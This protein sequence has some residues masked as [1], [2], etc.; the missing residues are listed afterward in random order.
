MVAEAT[1]AEETAA[2]ETQASEMV[3]EGGV[4]SELQIGTTLEIGSE[5][6]VPTVR[7][8]TIIRGKVDKDGTAIATGR[9]KTAVARVRLKKGTGK[10][11]INDRTFEQYFPVER[12][13][14]TIQQP[15]EVTG[16]LGKVDIWCRASGGGVNGQ[17]GAMILGIARAIQAIEPEQHGALSDGGFL[18][19]DDRMVERKKYGHRKARR[20]FQ[21]SKR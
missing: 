11:T 19:R 10:I 6:V 12:Q 4:A 17:A 14:L 8:P 3:A 13:R 2:E 21:F 18:T 16:L 7:L 15:L 1:A 20:S 5:A 9:R